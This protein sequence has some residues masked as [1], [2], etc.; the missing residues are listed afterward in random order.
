MYRAGRTAWGLVAIGAATAVGI[1]TRDPGFIIITFLG[2][3]VAVAIYTLIGV[4]LGAFSGFYAGWVDAAIMRL[5][6]IVLSFPALILII[7][8][9]SVSDNGRVRLGIDAPRQI[10]IDRSEVLD[11]IRSENVEAGGTETD[12]GAWAVYAAKKAVVSGQ[13]RPGDPLPPGTSITM[14]AGRS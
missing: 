10:R 13:M 9:V 5:A 7:T 6:D 8:V 1:T 4:I 2:A 14:Q 11:R 3:L 12:P